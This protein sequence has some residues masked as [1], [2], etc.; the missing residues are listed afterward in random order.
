M[1]NKILGCI[2]GAVLVLSGCAEKVNVN[3]VP[4]INQQNLLVRCTKNTPIPV[5]DKVDAE[6]KTV[7]DG[8]V[9]INTLQKWQEVYDVCASKDDALVDAV[10]KVQVPKTIKV[11]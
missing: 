9:L 7:Y 11:K 8:Q 10:I 5:S 1:K 3:P 4:L 6:G 2:V